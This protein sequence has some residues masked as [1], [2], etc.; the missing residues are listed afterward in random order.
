MPVI[1]VHQDPANRTLQIIARFD[2]AP[3]RVWQIYA[4]PRQ[5][6][7]VWGPP[8]HPA[9]FVQHEL[10]PGSRTHYFMTGPDGEKY[11]GFWDVT[12]VDAENSFDFDDGFALDADDFTPDPDLPVSKNTYRFAADGDGTRAE[13]TSVYDTEE[14]LNKVLEMGVVEGATAAINQIDGLLGA[15]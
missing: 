14:A 12:A 7:Q 10:R 11:A 13:F 5:L 8:S 6:E 3:S 9:T 1:D 4:D 15:D 2:A